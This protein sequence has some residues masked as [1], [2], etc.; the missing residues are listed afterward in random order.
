ML[1]LHT[2]LLV[3]IG[4]YIFASL[5]D[6]FIRSVG[7]EHIQSSRSAAFFGGV[8]AMALPRSSRKNQSVKRQQS[9][10]KI[11]RQRTGERIAQLD[12]G[13][14]STTSVDSKHKQ[15]NQSVE[16]VNVPG[17]RWGHSVTYLS[18]SNIA[19]FVGGQL[20]SNN[21]SL[22]LTNDVYAFD[23]SDNATKP[24]YQ[25]SSEN[26]APHAFAARALT[27]DDDGSDERVFLAG[28]A[29]DDCSVN[30]SQIF[31]WKAGKSWKDGQW[32]ATSPSNKDDVVPQL[33]RGAR[34]LQVPVQI[35]MQNQAARQ[36]EKDG[37]R[38]FMLVGGV[39]D[40]TTCSNSSVT[41]SDVN[42]WTLGAGAGNG[43][44]AKKSEA[45]ST[46]NLRSL[47][48]STEMSNMSFVDYSVVYLPANGTQSDRVLMMG[49]LDANGEFTPFNELWLLNLTSGMWSRM[50]TT[51]STASGLDIPL[52]RVGHTATRTENGTIIIYGGYT[53]L[54]QDRV[55]TSDVH[56][57]DYTVEPA[58]WSRVNSSN[59]PR[60]A[61]HTAFMTG[62]V[63]V[64]GFG[65]GNYSTSSVNS[66][67][68]SLQQRSISNSSLG[69]IQFLN[70]A[71]A[72]G[73]TWA[74]SIKSF[75]TTLP[76][77]SSAFT[78][79]SAVSS[80]STS[81]SST[82]VSSSK[83]SAT[84]IQQSKATSSA[85]LSSASSSSSVVSA[86]TAASTSNA[87][88]SDSP[89]T[90]SDQS[91]QVSSEPAASTTADAQPTASGTSNSSGISSPTKRNTAVLASVLGAAAVAASI[92]GLYAAYKRR[93][94]RLN[95][96][97]DS[98]SGDKYERFSSS[99]PG[100]PVSALWLHQLKRRA[101]NASGAFMN[102]GRSFKS[103]QTT[104][105]RS[106][107]AS[108]GVSPRSFVANYSTP[109]Q[110]TGFRVLGNLPPTSRFN[111]KRNK[112]MQQEAIRE[113]LQ[114]QEMVNGALPEDFLNSIL[115]D[116]EVRSRNDLRR[117]VGGNDIMIAPPR[118]VMM[119]RPLSS[120]SLESDGGIS[121]FS[122]PYLDAMNRYNSP[123]NSSSSQG[124][125]P[126]SL[127]Q[128]KMQ[129]QFDSPRFLLQQDANEIREI[130]NV[131][132][133][134][135]SSDSLEQDESDESDEDSPRGI[136]AKYTMSPSA[137]VA[138]AT[139]LSSPHFS[140]EL[141]SPSPMMPTRA[142]QSQRRGQQSTLRVINDIGF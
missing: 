22:V 9:I 33:R 32:S 112:V 37:G 80:S 31:M 114:N 62:Q 84:S 127:S 125:S 57:L 36:A 43:R 40:E 135:S 88:S 101:T 48:L 130:L 118:A 134:R 64:V 77:A 136:A 94:A 35:G 52:G 51:K 93:E 71:D 133:K 117:T 39:S 106:G 34:A 126:T 141:Q 12:A 86:S 131:I 81:A 74:D 109:M 54:D 72:S 2:F 120:D 102:R 21:N 78:S 67:N 44:K 11:D 108:A 24:W 68:S 41:H 59:A 53:S 75:S 107:A 76:S 13:N 60:R 7:Y 113:K 92:G 6:V 17:Q 26:L 3:L 20:P 28:G 82:F 49:G 105:P 29:T 137:L 123:G 61:Y 46:L 142:L 42:I 65:Q 25:L 5:E 91:S 1:F 66:T 87:E 129:D 58:V 27:H 99:A 79:T 119:H 45:A 110:D 8:N 38:S 73:W 124:N 56:V 138:A 104:S 97:N 10:F 98:L 103:R 69:P 83:P 4:P 116:D 121:H 15:S 132:Q 18:S 23:L 128:E 16:V 89:S 63:M 55:P 19:L 50:L 85:S 115:D 90:S 95:G 70:M 30:T 139:A 140:W 122:Y 111:I 96:D 47:S 100:P 14:G